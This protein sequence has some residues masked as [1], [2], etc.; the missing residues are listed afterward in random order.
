MADLSSDLSLRQLEYLVAVVDLGSITRA[1]AVLHVTQP[2]VSSQLALLERRIGGPLLERDRTGMTPTPAGE[3]LARSARRLL[4]LGRQGVADARDLA[5]GR[6]ATLAVGTLAT[7]ATWVLPP[8]VARW[9][10]ALPDVPVRIDEFVRRRYLERAVIDGEVDLGVG[11]PDSSFAGWVRPI[12]SERYVAVVPAALRSRLGASVGLRRLADE[13][14]VMLDADHGLHG[15]VR[16][17]CAAAGFQPRSAV[18]TRQVDT[19]IHLAAAGLGVTLAPANAVPAELRPASVAVRP[20]LRLQLSAFAMGPPS[21]QASLFVDLLEP[22]V[23]GLD[24]I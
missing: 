23:T 15:F 2:T 9:H 8:A 22:S 13:P 19:A 17:A 24:R 4:E 10:D 3:S 18:Q 16:Q 7:V 14:W 21:T 11:V 12:G 6:P 20:A 5:E 1:A